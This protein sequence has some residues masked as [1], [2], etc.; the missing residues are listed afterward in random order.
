M[1]AEETIHL[2]AVIGPRAGEGGLATLHVILL[3]TQHNKHSQTSGCVEL[4]QDLVKSMHKKETGTLQ[5]QLVT[6]TD[7][8]IGQDRRAVLWMIELYASSNSLGW[9]GLNSQCLSSLPVRDRSTKRRLTSIVLPSP[10][11]SLGGFS[12]TGASWQSRKISK[13][14]TL[15]ENLRTDCDELLIFTRAW[16]EVNHGYTPKEAW[17]LSKFPHSNTVPI[18]S[19]FYR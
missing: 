17:L 3:Q 9:A 10:L 5:Y 15:S 14:R 12:K 2:I 19:I 7:G 13:M 6:D 1:P 16:L 18:Y 4:L 8:P 11:K